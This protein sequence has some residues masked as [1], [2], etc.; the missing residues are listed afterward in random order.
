M[1]LS[2]G[3]TRSFLRA[4][5]VCGMLLA[6]LATRAMA[7]QAR[8]PTSTSW[9]V[10]VTSN[11]A[12]ATLYDWA[13]DAGYRA[14]RRHLSLAGTQNDTVVLDFG[15]PWAS[16]TSRGTWSFNATYGRFVT[17]GAIAEAVKQF[18]SGYYRGVGGDVQSRL[19][20]A[21]GT[22]N[23]GRYADSAH[24]R[25]WAEL[26]ATIGSWLSANPPG[27]QVAVRGASDIEI[28]YST[29]ERASAWVN[30]YASAWQSPYLL[31]H[32]GD[33]AGCPQRGTTRTPAA[34]NGGWHQDDVVYVSWRAS[35]CYPL[36]E[37]YSNAGGN[38]RQ[39]Q[40][41]S[42]HSYLAYGRPMSIL[43]P[44]SQSRACAQ[45]GGCAGTS[46][47]PAE[48]W[49]QLWSELNADGRTARNLSVSTDI[50]WRK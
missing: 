46:N 49:S 4:G 12:N 39:W 5:F 43:G 23:Y 50:E 15:Q 34:C 38:A 11:E 20:I 27:K 30:G 41:L 19:R 22:N 37:I 29:A 24:G 44:L 33:A 6:A 28:G 1:H 13:Y 47:T 36:P 42:L 16:G 17:T 2:R 8:P 18:A 25:A 10:Y 3:M 14:G 48:A 26:V 32:Y 45:R 35:P 9:Y 31:Y 40:Q 21:V 7:A